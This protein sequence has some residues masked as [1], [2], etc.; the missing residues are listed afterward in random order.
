MEPSSAAS[1]HSLPSRR[2]AA[3]QPEVCADTTAQGAA[4]ST[5]EPLASSPR[6][7]GSPALTARL[8]APSCAQGPLEPG[9]TGRR[10]ARG[11]AGRAHLRAIEQTAAPARPP[12]RRPRPRRRRCRLSCPLA[13]PGMEPPATRL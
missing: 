3:F 10:G 5:V 2:N 7:S 4:P 13:R 8:G 6:G 1:R 9:L 11:S 12:S